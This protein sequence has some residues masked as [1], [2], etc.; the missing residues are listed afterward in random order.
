MSAMQRDPKLK[1]GMVCMYRHRHG[2][3]RH[4]ERV[5]ECSCLADGGRQL[6]W[7]SVREPARLRRCRNVAGHAVARAAGSS[8]RP[9]LRASR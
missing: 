4:L 3:S 8:L 6:R 5:G 2:V 9:W 1:Y 7:G